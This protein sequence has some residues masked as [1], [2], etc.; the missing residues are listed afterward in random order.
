MAKL[1][2]RESEQAWSSLATSAAYF[3]GERRVHGEFAGT[4]TTKYHKLGYE[5]SEFFARASI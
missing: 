2:R 1:L 5:L 4:E 3:N